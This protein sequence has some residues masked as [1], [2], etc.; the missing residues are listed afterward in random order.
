M[1]GSEECVFGGRVEGCKGCV[2]ICACVTACNI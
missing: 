1:E 2:C